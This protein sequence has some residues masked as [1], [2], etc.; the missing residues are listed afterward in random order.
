MS[1]HTTKI[2]I[3]H[4]EAEKYAEMI[5]ANGYR[6]VE[7][8]KTP[9]E[10]DRVL[11]GTEV[12]LSMNIPTFL[13]SKPE[14]ASVQWIQSIGAGVDKLISDQSLP[15]HIIITR[16]VDQF[17]GLISEY[18]FAFLLFHCKNMPRLLTAQL[19]RQWDFFRPGS[20]EGKIIGVAGLG[21]IGGEIIN[22]SRAFH[23]TVHGLSYSGK[24]ADLVDHHYT[25][26]E[27]KKF[28]SELDYLILTLPLTPESKHVINRDVLLSMKPGSCL[29][30]VGRGQLIVEQ[31]LIDILMIRQDITAVLDVF[32][33]EPLDSESPLW[34]MPNVHITP[35][36]SGPSHIENVSRFFLDNLRQYEQGEPLEGIVNRGKGY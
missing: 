33:K 25:V 15:E 31:D 23:M 4:H 12:I 21:S 16:I 24:Q 11:P 13:L 29:V 3:Y 2:M 27:W 14:A 9:D 22:K 18:V 26:A 6:E 32:E 10:A 28:V 5:R 1:K 7:I 36:L 35:H 17:G 34:S 8:A 19:D 30:N 20:L